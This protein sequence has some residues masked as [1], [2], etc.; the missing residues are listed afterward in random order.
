VSCLRIAF[1]SFRIVG[2]AVWRPKD[3]SKE[4][5]LLSFSIANAMIEL[6]TKADGM[7]KTPH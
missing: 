3:T 4:S 5:I 2:E 1:T 7:C 6:T